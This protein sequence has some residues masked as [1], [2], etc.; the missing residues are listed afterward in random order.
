MRALLYRPVTKL[1]PRKLPFEQAFETL[2]SSINTNILG[3]N[4]YVI[5]VHTQ[6]YKFILIFVIIIIIIVTIIKANPTIIIIFIVIN[7]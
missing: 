2:T 6:K 4:P 3:L 5:L 7:P 1:R